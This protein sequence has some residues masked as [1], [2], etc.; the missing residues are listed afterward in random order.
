MT[1]AAAALCV[2]SAA[3]W[4]CRSESPRAEPL[5][6][7]A[8]GRE[9]EVVAQLMPEFTRRHPGVRVEVQQIPWTAAHEKLLTAF[10]GDSLPDLAPIG[11]TWVPEFQAIGAL[12]PL[13]AR[14][15][16][17]PLVSGADDFSGVW[18]T[19]VLSG[20]LYGIPWYVDTRV[21]FYRRDLLADAGFPSAPETWSEWRTAMAAV[22]ARSGNTRY[23]IL[24]PTDE[25]AQPV[26]LGLELG[27]PLLKD[28]ASRGAFSEPAFRSAA[29]FYVSFFRDSLSPVLSW[30][31]IG[32]VYQEFQRGTFAMWITGP[33][34]VG[35]F[36][37]K[38]P[39]EMQDSWGT[40]PIP[41][42]EKDRPGVSLAGGSS[43][44]L[45]RSS[46]RK[47]DAWKLVQYLSEPAT[48]ALFFRLV[49]DL[50]ARRSAWNDAAL[51]GE[52]AAAAFRVQLERVVS[53]P[54]VPEW[55]QIATR[56]FEHLEPAV[57]GRVAVP[58]ALAALDR[59]VDAILEK[60]RWMLGRGRIQAA[61]LGFDGLPAIAGRPGGVP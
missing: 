40:A 61:R 24:L 15:S 48:Q 55:E 58:Q 54:K 19:N 8:F 7:W 36:R 33:W 45:F 9:G 56:L 34:N 29:E 38:L 49:G 30:S 52:P 21:L 16:A 32:N 28:G 44:V 25:W 27:S 57:R 20:V 60:R 50:P 37:R 17:P 39:K 47:D 10:V 1:A 46:P 59:D 41:A 31:E 23:G 14:A 6:M 53:T 26:I 18:Q 22:R 2:C 35:E 51:A 43:L 5:R 11:N 4:S 42:P 12:E 3:S 13:D